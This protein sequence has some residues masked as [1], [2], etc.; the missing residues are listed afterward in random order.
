MLD[1]LLSENNEETKE[2]SMVESLLGSVEE[3][4]NESLL[5]N[6]LESSFPAQ[7]TLTPEEEKQRR[8]EYFLKPEVQAEI[9]LDNYLRNRG[10]IVSG[11]EKRAL[12]REFLRDIKKGKYRKLFLDLINQPDEDSVQA[13]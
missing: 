12:R 10:Y 6:D 7:I 8:R 4:N 11:K 13:E 1:S 2:N 3:Q 9:L 5:D